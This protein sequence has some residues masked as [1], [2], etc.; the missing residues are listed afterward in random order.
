[1]MRL[2]FWLLSLVL[3]PLSLWTTKFGFLGYVFALITIVSFIVGVG[4]IFQKKQTL[5]KNYPLLGR[6]RYVFEALRPKIYQYFVESDLDGRPINRIS[7]SV[8][9]QRAKKAR[10]TVPFG[11]QLDVYEDGYEW[12]N[13]SM[14]PLNYH[15]INQHPRILVGNH[16]CQN[17]Y[18]C[19]LFNISAM[20]YGSLSKN[21]IMALNKGAQLGKFAHNTGEGGISSFHL[22]HGGDLIWQIGTGYF[23]CRDKDGNFNEEMFAERANI[24]N[25]KM[26]EI[27]ISQ[28]AK[29]GHGGILPAVKNTPEIA[30]IRGVEAGTTVLSPPNHK[31]FNNHKELCEFIAKLRDLSGGKPI[32]IKLCIGNKT[33]FI[34]LCKQMI[35]SDTY[36]DYIA[37]DGA[38][39]GTG[40]APLEFT[41]RLGTPLIDGLVFVKDIL[42]G[43][44]IKKYI[45][46]IASGKVMTAFDLVKLTSLGADIVYSARAMMLALGCIQ[47]LECNTNN[48]PT[49]IATQVKELAEGLDVTDKSVRVHSYHANTLHAFAEMLGAAGIKEVSD[50]KRSLIYRRRDDNIVK[51]YDQIYPDIQSGS[52]LAESIPERLKFYFS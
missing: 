51:R 9:Y 18:S 3:I 1:M 14:N 24:P 39:G 5:R 40:A 23:G 19:S 36:P 33:E 27:K 41:N 21:A 37:V 52:L 7:R 16:Q 8:V 34:E 22:E 10:D 26:I 13:H 32:G 48:C 30:E 42:D 47:A 35:E 44:D 45:K 25:V 43:F 15:E 46:I 12:I 28:G 29:P 17:P 38:E 20:S 6:I 31:A 2:K 4:D 11:T 50:L 49:G